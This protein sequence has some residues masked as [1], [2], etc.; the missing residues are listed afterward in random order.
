MTGSGIAL[1]VTSLRAVRRSTFWWSVGIA[2]LVAATVAF[3]PAFRGAS[4]ISQAID[5]LPGGVIDALG[6]RNFGTPAGF[7]RG[8]LYELFIP[9]LFTGAGVALVNGQTAS[10]EAA[11]RLELFLAQPVSHRSL[12]GTRVVASLFALAAIVVA[13]VVV[14][15]VMDAAIGL[16]IAASYIVAT[17]ALCGLLAAVHA[18]V[19][20]LVACLRP[21]TS[22]VL[23]AGIGLAIAG[24]VVAV[25]FRISSVLDPW[26]IISPWEWALGGNPL[27]QS[28]E[29]WRFVVLGGVT[30]ALA[31]LGTLLV[32]RRDVAA[33]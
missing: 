21:R 15:V 5:N 6:L 12:F 17:A 20:Y 24:Y 22:L 31:L 30:L 10:D 14:Q 29:A 11:G 4:G 27:E 9:L 28:A 26:K 32:G 16:Q 13:T 23:G 33:P 18:S 3:W 25:L 2:M 19:A 1:L 7:L 8:N